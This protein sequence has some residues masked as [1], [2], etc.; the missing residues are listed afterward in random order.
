MIAKFFHG[1]NFFF[2]VLPELVG[3]VC[4]FISFIFLFAFVV[5]LFQSLLERIMGWK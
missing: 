5:V 4:G 2:E 3:L 1:F